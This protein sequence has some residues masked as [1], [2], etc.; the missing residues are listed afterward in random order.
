MEL[1]LVPLVTTLALAS[2]GGLSTGWE[3]VGVAVGEGDGVAVALGEGDGEGLVVAV[4]EGE[5]LAC[6]VFK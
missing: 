2:T 5:G 1:A 3:L 4:A 6:M